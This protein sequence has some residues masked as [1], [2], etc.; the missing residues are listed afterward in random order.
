MK[1]TFSILLLISAFTSFAQKDLLSGKYTREQLQTV[2]IP[3]EKWVPFPKPGDAAWSKANQATLQS[4]VQQAEQYLNYSWPSIPATKSLLIERTGDRAQYQAI[5]NERRDALVTLLLGEIHE[6]KGR[7]L[8]QIMSVY[9]FA[10]IR[11]I[12]RAI[13]R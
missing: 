6:N 1:K 2:L 7:F 3:L 9:R 8:D 4:Y 12:A 5:S 13:Q 11:V 10:C